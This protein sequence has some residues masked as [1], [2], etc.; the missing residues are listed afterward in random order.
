MDNFAK[1]SKEM[2]LNPQ[3]QFLYQMHL[4]NLKGKGGVDNEDGS[5]S[6]LRQMT[7]SLGGKTYNLP[8][9][10][11]GKILETGPAIDRAKKVGLDKFPSYDSQEEAE[12]RYQ[13]MHDYMEDDT[14]QFLASRGN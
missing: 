2:G 7:V 1:A 12:A 11:D 6:S 3:E 5:R 9:V 10:W 4:K 8:T 14:K 13:K